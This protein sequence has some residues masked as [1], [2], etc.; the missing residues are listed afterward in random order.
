[1][2]TRKPSIEQIPPQFE[3]FNI[4]PFKGKFYN[5]RGDQKWGKYKETRFP[6]KLLSKYYG[7]L[8]VMLG[9]YEEGYKPS[10]KN[11]ALLNKILGKEAKSITEDYREYYLVQVDIDNPEHYP[12]FKD[13]E[14]LTVRTGRE[15]VGYHLFLISTDPIRTVK[16]YPVEGVEVRSIGALCP[17]PPSRHPDTRIRYKVIK[18]VPILEVGNAYQF[19]TDRIPPELNPKSTSDLQ[20]TFKGKGK[21]KKRHYQRGRDRVL[22]QEV[23]DRIVRV[24]DGTYTPATGS[25]LGRN[26]LI[27][28]LSGWFRKSGISL[29]SALEVTKALANSTE[30]EEL[31][32]RLIVCN[33]AYDRED[34]DQLLGSKGVRDVLRS[35]DPRDWEDRYLML[36]LILEGSKPWHDQDQVKYVLGVYR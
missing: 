30:D 22:S 34:L 21:G 17:I 6:R 26:D 15:E 10:K 12:Y 27:F 25:T 36:E 3:R 5:Y 18:D 24:I 13:V 16:D 2:S 14:T 31:E 8:G 20:S 29:E 1:M 32:S 11:E 23:V 35:K 28:S 7:N 19:T 9:K 33:R 4:L